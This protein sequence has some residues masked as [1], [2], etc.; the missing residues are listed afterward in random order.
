[1]IIKNILT[2]LVETKLNGISIQ[3]YMFYV[4]GIVIK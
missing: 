4:L 1:M 3:G 2:I